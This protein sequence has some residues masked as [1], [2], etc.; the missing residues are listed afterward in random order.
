MEAALKLTRQAVTV[1]PDFGYAWE[2]VSELEFSFGHVREALVALDKSLVLT[3]RS[4][5]ALALKGFLLAAQNQTREAI[6]WFNRALAADSALGNAWLGRGVSRIRGGD[7]AGGREDLLVAAALEPQ[8]AELRSYLGKA[9]ANV[10]DFSHAYKELQLAKTLDP[11]DPT[12]WLYSALLD[13]Q[14]NRINEA[15]QDLEKS[16]SLNDNRSV[17]RSQLLLEQDRAVRSANL[18]A[19]YSDAG[20][21]EVGIREAL[22]AVNYDYANYSAHLFLANSYSQLV[23]PNEIN[24][25]YETAME[26]EYLLAN[27]LSPAAAGTMS[28]ALSQQDYGQLFER[29]RLGV[30][31]D[32]EYLSR[33]AWNESGAQY[34]IDGNFSFNI[35]EDYKSDPGQ[36]L[37]NDFLQRELIVTL[38]QQFSPR[39]SVYV[40]GLG[41]DADGGD[42]HQY[43]TPNLANPDVRFKETQEPTAVLG[44]HHEGG[45]GV[46]TLLLLARIEDTYSYTNSTQPTLVAF[47]PELNPAAMPG[48]TSLVRVDGINMH[49]SFV[50]QLAIYSGELQQ[51][52]QTL[53]HNTIVGLRLQYGDFETANLQTTPS[54]DNSLFTDPPAAQDLDTSFNRVSFYGYHEW[55]VLDPLQMFGGLA[56]DRMRF[57]ANAQTAPISSEEKSESRFSPKAGLIWRPMK[58]MTIRGAYTRS[59]GGA[60]VDQSYQ[61][62]P[63]QVAGFIQSFRSLIPESVA[64]ESPGAQFETFELSFE[65]NFDTGI[66]LGLSAEMLNSQDRQTVGAFERPAF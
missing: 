6:V 15:I 43:Y 7:V 51:I 17:Y 38:K 3:P 42:L 40:Q 16:V 2:R 57:P 37:N 59:L 22:R 10:G 41:Y 14:D 61:L 13:Q 53:A 54:A 19:M 47:R 44:L 58:E 30:V 18:A 12:A 35:E 55:Q 62:E 65:Q 64:A 4:A 56:Y 11:H 60:S 5:Q 1:A 23:D 27:L 63:S 9:Y 48:V 33:G 50:N 8:R 46:H 20:M 29:D 25:R 45:P 24:L 52:W 49:Q 39:D 32:T 66:Y 31:S 21:S 28:Q 34:G 26:N 36:R